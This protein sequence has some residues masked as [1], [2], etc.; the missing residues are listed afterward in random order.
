MYQHL[1]FGTKCTTFPFYI[2]VCIL[3]YT[4]SSDDMICRT[5]TRQ[6]PKFP[7]QQIKYDWL[8]L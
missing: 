2:P 1:T 5:K 6:L 4:P 7:R 3:V 8:I